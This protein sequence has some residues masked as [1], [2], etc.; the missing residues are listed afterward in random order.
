MPTYLQEL[1]ARIEQV[2]A[3][4]KAQ[5]EGLSSEDLNWKADANSW[6]V[7]QCLDH[8]IT[9]NELYF[10]ILTAA[11]NAQPPQNIFSR[12]KLFSGLFG[13]LLRKQLGAEVI[14]KSKSPKSFQPATSGLPADILSQFLSHQ[15]KLIAHLKAL[16]D[17]D[18]SKMIMISPAAAFVTYSIEDA[19]YIL[20]GHE[21]RHL[22]Q[23]K[24]V[25][26]MPSFPT[27]LQN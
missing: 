20:T 22:A 15:T 12:L 1:I 10:P 25:M 21:E 8:L 13:R 11:Q 3:K 18:F 4:A 5:F 14:N 2:S 27:N 16:P 7:A 26:Q 9:T 17:R 23:A 6:S 24:R 19:L